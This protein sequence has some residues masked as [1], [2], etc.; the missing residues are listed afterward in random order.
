MISNKIG[1]AMGVLKNGLVD[2]LS[3]NRVNPNLITF[4]G[5]TINFFAAASLAYGHNWLAGILMIFAGA[6]DILD[7]A[8]ARKSGR[9]SSF[10]A[11]FDSVIDRYSDLILYIGL[12]TYYARIGAFG[13]VI[14]TSV[15]SMGSILVSYTRARAENVIES[16]K[17]GFWE[18]P[19][20]IVL[21]II[22]ALSNRLDRALWILAIFANITVI[23][24]MVYTWIQTTGEYEESTSDR[25]LLTT[26]FKIAFKDFKRETWQ[27]DLYC[28]AVLLVMF[29]DKLISYIF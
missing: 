9:V 4:T 12:I 7:G 3:E 24:R 19:E 11:F 10:G 25:K 18:R 8:V 21:L 20:R 23:H 17:V 29:G 5:L 16:C 6:F 27:Y 13:T 1:F 2:F 28:I 14:L 15:A 26:F 22:A